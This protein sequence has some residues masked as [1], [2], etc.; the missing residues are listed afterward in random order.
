MK[1]SQKMGTNTKVQQNYSYEEI[2]KND[3]IPEEAMDELLTILK[4]EEE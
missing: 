2:L 4:M 3:N 1:N